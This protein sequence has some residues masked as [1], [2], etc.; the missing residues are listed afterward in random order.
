[1]PS[2]AWSGKAAV[3]APVDVCSIKDEPL[4]DTASNGCT[5]GNAYTCSDQSPWAVNEDLAY[6]FAA[7]NIAGGSES[8]WCCACYELTFT[9]T[10]LAGKKM[11]VQATNTG[12]DLGSNQFDIAMP[13]GGVG[14]YNGCT[15]E[16]GA[17]S[18]GWGAQYGGISANSTCDTFPAALQAGCHWRF[19]WFEGADNPTV[20]FE[21]VQ[22][23]SEITAK[24]GCTRDDDSSEPLVTD[25]STAATASSTAAATAASSSASSP[26]AY[27]VTSAAASSPTASSASSAAASSPAAYSA[28]S[29]AASSVAASSP[30]AYSASSAAAVPSSE[31]SASSAA[32]E[33]TSTSAS[34][35]YSSAGATPAAASS[36]AAAASDDD[37]DVHYVYKYDL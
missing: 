9:S 32:A 27:S 30:V 29:A 24:T 25:V 6:G 13:G 17:P 11:V 31:V 12:A 20:S 34:V 1:M 37:C 15:D 23:P 18:E 10:A 36:S 22:C 26:A 28:S 16:W 3:S 5:G 4:T 35:S 19:D 21:Q 33:A 7:V 14:I 2:C 8:S